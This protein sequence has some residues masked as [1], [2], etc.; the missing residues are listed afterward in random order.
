MY[1][2]VPSTATKLSALRKKQ[3]AIPTAAI[4][5]PA[6]TGPITRDTLNAEELSAIAFI[7]SAFPTRSITN[8]WRV[9]TSN[10]TSSPKKAASAITH[11]T[12][13]SPKCVSTPSDSASSSIPDCSIM[14]KR[15]L[16]TR[17]AM[18]PP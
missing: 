17:S 11:G 6:I 2:S 9:G 15:R 16:F 13:I 7:T 4:T 5:P 12:V 18:T 8:A 14:M 1:A 10:A 3:A